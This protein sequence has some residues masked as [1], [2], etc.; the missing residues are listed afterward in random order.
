[1]RRNVLS[2]RN[3]GVWWRR[4]WVLLPV[5]ARRIP[6][7]LARREPSSRPSLRLALSVGCGCSHAAGRSVRR[8]RVPLHARRAALR[9]RDA[10]CGAAR[11][12]EALQPPCRR[13]SGG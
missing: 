8:R 12:S 9:G 1:M 6:P 3:V 2:C 11:E 7:L 5:V 4:I 10:P 13:A